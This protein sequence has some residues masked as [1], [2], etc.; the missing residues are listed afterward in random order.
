MFGPIDK[1]PCSETIEG[2][3]GYVGGSWCC[4]PESWLNCDLFKEQSGKLKWEAYYWFLEGIGAYLNE[5]S[6]P[7]S[8]LFEELWEKRRTELEESFLPV[9]NKQKEENENVE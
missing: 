2:C 4:D 5:V 7:I 9:R 8:Q 3:P 6:K 1:C